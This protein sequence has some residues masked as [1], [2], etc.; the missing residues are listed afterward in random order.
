MSSLR[1]TQ[2]VSFESLSQEYG[3]LIYSRTFLVLAVIVAL[4]GCSSNPCA[5][6]HV[7]Q[8]TDAPRETDPELDDG[9][10]YAVPV[11]PL[12]AVSP[13]EADPWALPRPH[14]RTGDEVKL[15]GLTARDGTKHYS[16]HIAGTVMTPTLIR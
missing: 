3:R 12:W 8:Y 1:R 16:L 7:V 14:P 13:G 4:L 15:C 10:V 2:T 11:T 9:H 5:T 6:L